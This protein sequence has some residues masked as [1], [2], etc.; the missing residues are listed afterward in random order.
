MEQLVARIR[1]EVQINLVRSAFPAFVLNRDFMKY[2]AS[3]EY[4]RQIFITCKELKKAKLPEFVALFREIQ[5]PSIH[6][7][8]M[9]EFNEPDPTLHDRYLY[10]CLLCAHKAILTQDQIDFMWWFEECLLMNKLP[11]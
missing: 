2:V 1:L 7:F 6:S 10:L 8:F 3:P 4:K 11:I 9:K 5:P